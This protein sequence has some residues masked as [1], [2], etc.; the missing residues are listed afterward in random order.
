MV[1]REQYEQAQE[2][3]CNPD[4]AVEFLAASY[5]S[6]PRTITAIAEGKKPVTQTFQEDENV[7][8][9]KFIKERNEA[10]SNIHFSVN[11]VAETAWKKKAKKTDVTGV[12]ALHVDLD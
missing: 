5:R 8:L 9:G 11:Q 1:I 7:Q 6:L 2:L 10:K 12:T 4:S 3:K